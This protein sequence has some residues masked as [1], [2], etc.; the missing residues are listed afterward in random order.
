MTTQD[1]KD[2][3]EILKNVGQTLA[4]LG[5]AFVLWRW[6]R[7]RNDRA[8]DIL[9]KLDEQ[10]QMRCKKEKEL[11]DDNYKYA[12][13]AKNIEQAVKTRAVC[14][15]MDILLDFYV[16]L[17][18]VRSARQV[19]DKPLSI[20]FRYWLAHYFR[21]DRKEFRSYVDKFYPTLRRWLEKDCR[22]NGPSAGFFR[23]A[24]LFEEDLLDKEKISACCS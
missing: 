15:E 3:S 4:Y 13:F 17:Y 12:D 8:T 6:I 14:A 11:I 16:M 19:P 23:P 21:K 2:Y 18:G 9:M 5:G 1:L 22:E 7:E 10:F 24:E 20:C